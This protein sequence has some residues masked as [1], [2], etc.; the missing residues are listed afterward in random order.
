MPIIHRDG[1]AI[2]Y[3]AVGSGPC[4]VMTHA[5]ACDRSLFQHQ[6]NMLRPRF[7]VINIDLRGHGASGDSVWPFTLYDLVDDVLAVLDAERVNKAVWLGL[8]IGSMLSMR[9]AIRHPERVRA[10]VLLNGFARSESVVGAFRLGV[11][12]L[13]MQTFGPRPMVPSQLKTFLGETTLRERKDLRERMTKQF[14][15]A[16]VPSLAEALRT[17][18]QR[19]DILAALGGIS[20]PTLV[21]AGAQDKALPQG[22]GEDLA[23][24]IPRAEL[25]TLPNCGHLSALE[26]PELV[27]R[28]LA[29]FL[30]RLELSAAWAA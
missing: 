22:A 23:R 11:A 6:V 25:V 13:I 15:A 27:N 19:D 14:M 1:L 28:A 18:S 26:A 8:S 2:A 5:F 12:R 21:I 29:E 17:L 7:R 30:D 24:R 4:V 16:R 9:A 10:L 20:C 3:D